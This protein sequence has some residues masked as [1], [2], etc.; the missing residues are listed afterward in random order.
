MTTNR[1]SSSGRGVPA[2]AARDPVG[3]PHDAPPQR[4]RPATGPA[5]ARELVP[6]TAHTMRLHT[7]E[8]WVLFNGQR[9]D[10][11]RRQAALTG[12]RRCAAVLGWL[13]WCAEQDNPYADWAL[14][15]FEEQLARTRKR[16]DE[17]TATCEQALEQLRDGGLVVSVMASIRPA[18]VELA[19]SGPYGYA[20]A[21]LV[22]QFDQYVRSVKTLVH[23]DCWT[24]AQ[25]RKAVDAMSARLRR[26]FFEPVRWEKGLRREALR[27]LCRADF[28]ADAPAAAAARVSTAVAL[29]GELPRAVLDR[30]RAPRHVRRSVRSRV[31]SRVAASG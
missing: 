14:V 15:Q 31:P 23:L 30:A 12:A 18:V 17:A 11:A 7:R 20:V 9:P 8:A 27:E 19:F 29:F 13:C 1:D 2:S 25:G 21:Q 4:V 28:L 24:D 16:L 10:P 5:P 22:L 3:S 6:A 26:Q